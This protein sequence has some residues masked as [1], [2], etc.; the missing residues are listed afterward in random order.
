M[1]DPTKPAQPIEA[2]ILP[3]NQG[4]QVQQGKAGAGVL[5]KIIPKKVPADQAIPGTPPQQNAPKSGGLGLF[6]GGGDDENMT[7]AL[8]SFPVRGQMSLGLVVLVLLLGGFGY[9]SATTDIAGAIIAG[10]QIEV[11]RNRQIVQH[12]DGGVVSEILVDEGDLVRVGDPLVRLDSNLVMSELTIVEGQY[13]ELVARRARL[14]AERLQSDTLTFDQELLELA[15]VDKE[16][17]ELVDG[18]VKL[19][20]ARRESVRRE[21]DGLS[22]RSDQILDQIVGIDAQRVALARQLDL[23]AT[24]LADQQTLLNRGLAQASRVLSLQR[25]EA[26]L[27]GTMGELL[28]QRAQAEGR[29]TEL[30]IEI[31]K[32]ETRRREEAITT[33]RDLQYR[34]REL[35]EQRRALYE[36]VNRMEIKAPVSGIIYG[37]A[38]F[39]ERS[40]IRPADPVLFIVPQDR[41][42]VIAAQVEPIHI[43][44]VFVDQEVVL[45]FSALDSRKTPEVNGTVML[46]SADAFRDDGS[47]VSYYRAEIALNE[48]EFARLPAGTILIPGMPVEAYIQTDARTPMAYLFKPFTDY[49]RRAFTES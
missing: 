42:L 43:D 31:L 21:I 20:D 41:P 12:P 27:S 44:Q 25:E 26:R 18:Q 37:M 34:E 16:V 40:V 39:A 8:R 15:R 28:A 49:F 7:E 10:G 33:L 32:L 1:S 4:Q 13:F 17:A 35:A 46:V 29:I 36:R 24:E 6:G 38:V 14:N 30:D 48:G 19:F 11:D 3:P 5:G 22:K 23:I 45:R 47:G 9:W 2:E